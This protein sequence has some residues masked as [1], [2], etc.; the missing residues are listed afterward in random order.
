MIESR[1]VSR[2]PT[3]VRRRARRPMRPFAVLSAAVVVLSVNLIT[4]AT[5]GADPYWTNAIEL[6]GLATLNQTAAATGP[7]VCTSSGNCVSGGGYTDGV[8]NVQAFLSQETNGVWSS[9]VEIGAAL[10]VGGFA[11]VTAIS[12]PV[13]GSCTAVGEYSDNSSIGH[14]F[15]ISQTNGTWGYPT[16]VPDFTTLAFEDGSVMNSLSCTSV[17]TCVGA[18]TYSDHAT[19]ISQPIIYTE[20]NGVWA[21]PVEALGAAAANPSGQTV[22]GDL[23][24]TSPTTCVVGGDFFNLTAP[25]E[26]LRAVPVGGEER[27]V[28]ERGKRAGGRGPHPR[29]RRR[30]HHAVVWRHRRLC[31]RWGLR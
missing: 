13:A 25:N 20:T 4:S 27:C 30:T 12:C 11:Q 21:V 3:I 15:V 10:N 14:T 6:P 26:F 1:E 7:I 2:S 22:V 17:T 29:T 28:G 16:E 5:A 8:T 18:G 24:C 9:A 19:S 23:D 31:R